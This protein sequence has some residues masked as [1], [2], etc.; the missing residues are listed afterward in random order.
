MRIEIT[1]TGRLISKKASTRCVFRLISNCTVTPT[2]SMEHR[3]MPCAPHKVYEGRQGSQSRAGGVG[4]LDSSASG[5][6]PPITASL[7]SAVSTT[8]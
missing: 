5:V 6:A 3:A 2:P 8:K 7:V 4:S 1:R